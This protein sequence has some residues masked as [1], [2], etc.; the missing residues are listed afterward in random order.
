MKF[1][2][3]N[4][5]LGG[6]I[7]LGFGLFNSLREGGGLHELISSKNNKGLG[8]DYSEY[9]PVVDYEKPVESPDVTSVNILGSKVLITTP[10]GFVRI[11][12]DHEVTKAITTLAAD[13]M[14]DIL[15]TFIPEE[16]LPAFLSGDLERLDTG[17]ICFAKIY[18]KMKRVSPTPSLLVQTKEGMK[19]HGDQ[20][21]SK[22]KGIMGDYYDKRSKTLNENFDAEFATKISDI[23]ILP[24]HQEGDSHFAFS[25]FFKL[26]HSGVTEISTST[27]SMI[28]TKNTMP[29]LVVQG[30]RADLEWTRRVCSEWAKE[31]IRVNRN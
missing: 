2:K 23:V 26:S 14:N 5:I 9:V 31:F 12:A 25:G 20:I 29:Q 4:L 6:L 27:C 10:R 19:K 16:Q 22:M 8:G 17:R 3:K 24:I 28:Y 18:K 13:P 15:A 30:N 21:F 11:E 7:G 1:T